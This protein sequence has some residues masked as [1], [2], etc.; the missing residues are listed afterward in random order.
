MSFSLPLEFCRTGTQGSSKMP[1]DGI[2]SEVQVLA[3]KI[4]EGLPLRVRGMC[5]EQS[6]R[7]LIPAGWGSSAQLQGSGPGPQWHCLVSLSR[8]CALRQSQES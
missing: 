3:P 8:A 6:S 4:F 2:F 7:K 5:P 1:T